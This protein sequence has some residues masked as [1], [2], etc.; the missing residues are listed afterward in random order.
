MIM[1]QGLPVMKLPGI[2]LTQNRRWSIYPPLLLCR[3]SCHHIVG[4]VFYSTFSQRRNIKECYRILDVPEGCSLE[5]VKNSY[6]KLA[7]KYHPDSG[8]VTA[9]ADKFMQIDKAYKA[10]L[11]HLPKEVKKEETR[12]EE[13]D[14]S[15]YKTPQHRQ[16]L[17][18][19][20]VGYGTPSQRQRQYMQF[21]VD[22][23]SDQ[24]LEF[25]KKNLEREYAENTMLVKD[26]KQSK[27]AKLTQAVERLVEDLIQ[28]SMAKGEFDNLSGKGKPLEKFSY[29]P[30]V[31]PMTHNL[32]R[33]L[34]DNGYQP[35]WIVLQ[36]EIRETIDKL[37]SEALTSRKKLGDPL[38]YATNKRWDEICERLR[39][40]ISKLNKKINDFNLVVPLL[41]RQMVHFNADKEIGRIEQAH[42]SLQ[43][44]ERE[45]QKEIQE[46]KHVDDKQFN[47]KESLINWIN[48]LKMS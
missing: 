42:L 24:V 7:K 19:E 27:K 40:D 35:E 30:H 28:E 17:S 48:C 2:L 6:L 37:R 22:R 1:T 14:G 47:L 11:L 20:G 9:D 10:L 33:I 36:K 5:E 26:I 3:I 31:D 44:E 8:S 38:T 15:E 43:E 34:I 18:Y 39:E 46:S 32:N 13:D 12:K 16:Y 45:A 25:R 41:S 4:Y 29:C 21:R 23:A